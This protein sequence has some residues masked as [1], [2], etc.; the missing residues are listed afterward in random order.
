M[1]KMWLKRVVSVLLSVIIYS[2][3]ISLYAA[4][5]DQNAVVSPEDKISKELYQEFS[6]LQKEASN[7]SEKKSRYGYGTRTLIRFR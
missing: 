4:N 3:P 5:R 7:L 6:R 1:N 2:I